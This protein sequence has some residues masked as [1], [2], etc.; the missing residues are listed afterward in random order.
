MFFLTRLTSYERPIS[1]GKHLHAFGT[2]E[3]V[4]KNLKSDKNY[5]G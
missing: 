3:P 1:N 4:Y 2:C 5:K